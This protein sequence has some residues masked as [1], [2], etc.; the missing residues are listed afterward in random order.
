MCS[1]RYLD[2]Y[3]CDMFSVVNVHLDHSMF[4][5]VLIVEGMAVVVNV[6]LFL[7]NVMSPH[8]AVCN[9]SVRTLVK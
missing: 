7:M 3:N 1:R 8:H 2:V 9:I 4:C 5:V 6:M